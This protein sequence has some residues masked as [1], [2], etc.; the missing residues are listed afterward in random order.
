MLDELKTLSVV[1]STGS[2]H[3]AAERRGLTQS[4]VTRQIQRLEELLGLPLFDRRVKPL[5][6]TRAG[7]DVLAR[8]RA[9]LTS[10]DTLKESVR[11]HGSPSGPIRIGLAHGLS[12]PMFSQPVRRLVA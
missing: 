12:E 7:R 6:L 8:G 2:L 4:A 10:V 3:G 9:I 5:K 11:E 1:A